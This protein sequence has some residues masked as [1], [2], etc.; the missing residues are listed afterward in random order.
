MWTDPA[1]LSNDKLVGL[2]I[3]RARVRLDDGRIALLVKWPSG[4]T[5]RWR[6][7]KNV[8]LES[9]R[10]NRFTVAVKAIEAVEVP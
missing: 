4:M 2:A 8:R 9:G 3:Q 6:H 7:E 1:T 10:G 5:R